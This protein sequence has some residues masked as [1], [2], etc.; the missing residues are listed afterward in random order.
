MQKWLGTFALCACLTSLGTAQT[1]PSTQQTFTAK[2]ATVTRQGPTSDYERLTPLIPGA[3]VVVGERKGDW[4]RSVQSGVWLDS[5]TGTL[6]PGAVAPA[7]L[8][9]ATLDSFPNGDARLTLTAS[10]VPEIQAKHSPSTGVLTLRLVGTEDLIF[11]L[12]KPTGHADFLHSVSVRPDGD[13]TVIE[14]VSGPHA[15]G[16]YALEPGGKPGEVVL[17]FR[18]PTPKAWK[19]LIITLD[20]GHGGPSDPGT[21]GHGGLAEKVLNLRVTEA[22]AT[23]LRA[24]GATVVMT[25]TADAD[26]APDDKGASA[27]L[28][29]RVDVSV[30][31]QAHL[32]LSLHHNARPDVEEGKIS[33][34]TDI[35]YY[36]PISEKF[37]QALADP[38]ADAI[39]EPLRTSRFRSFHVI[40]QSFSPSVLVEFQY[41]ANPTLEKSVLDTKGY[42]EKAADGVVKGLEA[43]LR[44]LPY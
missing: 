11:E 8:K 22:L 4:Y 15:L 16:G 23:K 44:S 25:R 1:G 2:E 33:H 26:V 19:D 10:A 21:V 18:K 43:Y 12:V 30:E 38:I 40:R 37:A 42:P 3:K 13:D 14:V 41:L 31:K 29:A 36:H 24:L 7:Q 17:R 5:R 6:N 20:A 35:Y 32:F 9:N 39:A 28:Q 34:G 27:E